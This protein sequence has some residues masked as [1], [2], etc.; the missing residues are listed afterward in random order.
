MKKVELQSIV[1]LCQMLG[2]KCQFGKLFQDCH[3]TVEDNTT[4]YPALP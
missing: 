1:L 4:T 2:K 3:S